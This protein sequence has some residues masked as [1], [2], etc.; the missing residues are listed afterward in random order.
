MD[1]REAIE[2]DAS[3]KKELK[4][5]ALNC[6]LDESVGAKL[7]DDLIDDY[8]TVFPDDA[9]KGMIFLGKD[10]ASYKPGN[11]KVDLKKAIIAGFEFFAAFSKP[12]SIFNYIQL[13]ITSIFLI[14]KATKQKLSS[15]D[16]RI[17]YLLHKSD[18]YDIG[19]EEKQFI[20]EAQK[21]Y[22]QNEGKIIERDE[23]VAAINS[24][25]EIKAIDI[26]DGNVYLKEVV[27][28]KID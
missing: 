2:Y 8:I 23:I 28:G 22:L 9:R 4:Q 11:I 7:I 5:A 20:N 25:Y 21:W 16:S 13:L 14:G 15:I 17:V 27:W 19:I 12:N 10:A 6:N 1:R 3:L 18:A 26:K 24:L